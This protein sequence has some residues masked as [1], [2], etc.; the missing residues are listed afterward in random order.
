MERLCSEFISKE[1]PKDL[2]WTCLYFHNTRTLAKMCRVLGKQLE[3]ERYTKL[4]QEIRAVINKTWL[5]SK[6]GHYSSKSQTS[7]IL[8]LA[9][10]LVPEENR[11]QLI[12]NIGQT[13][14]KAD[15]GKLRVG[16]IGLP[17][18]MESL[19]ENGLGE[20]VYDAV[21]HSEF[22]GWGYMIAQGA[23]T[24]WE[25]WG[26]L[27]GGYEAEESM[28]M[29]A[30]VG[31][32]FYE[33]IAGIQEPSFYGNREFGPGYSHFQIKPHVLGDLTQAEA[34]I[35]TVRGVISSSWKRTKDSFVLE[36]EIPVNSTA[37]ASV[38]TL[39]LKRFT[40]TEGGKRVWND[41][42]Y[43]DGVEGIT[44]ARGNAKWVTFDVGSGNYRFE[45]KAK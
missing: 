15:G 32:L 9:L 36:I 6:T 38:S 13:I 18:F 31:R 45:L 37:K 28:T 5:D 20:I 10:D 16:H 34:S 22:P 44:G 39:G 17:G 35:K 21:N 3:A 4:A 23:T 27:K 11:L 41:K 1:T 12:E 42:A 29:L 26:M 40:I 33:S 14:T 25:S 19:V 43:V 8:P 7:E 24:V 2:I 30:G